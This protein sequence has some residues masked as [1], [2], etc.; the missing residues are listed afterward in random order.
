MASY[1]SRPRSQ[2]TLHDIRKGICE[3]R[4]WILNLNLKFGQTSV[5]F[6][7]FPDYFSS[8]PLRLRTRLMREIF[9]PSS[10]L[11]ASYPTMLRHLYSINDL[12]KK[13]GILAPSD[14]SLTNTSRLYDLIGRPLDKIPTLHV[15]GT[16][17]KVIMTNSFSSRT[18]F[19]PTHTSIES[20]IKH[21]LHSHQYLHNVFLGEYIV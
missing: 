18:E 14:S 15:G 9:C 21:Q 16:N 10:G 8:S 3:R 4:S 7:D 13:D 17:G 20:K 1:H 19:E 11:A 12:L 2:R 6:G 5:T